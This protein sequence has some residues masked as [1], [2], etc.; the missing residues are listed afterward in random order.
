MS[1]NH[2]NDAKTSVKKSKKSWVKVAALSGFAAT[3]VVASSVVAACSGVQFKS[4]AQIVVSDS[5]STLADQSFSESAYDGLKGF[6]GDLGINTVPAASDSKV[7]ENNGLWKKPGQTDDDRVRTYVNVK[8]DGSNIVI[9]TG[10]NQSNALH[11]ITSQSK[12]QSNWNALKD[13]GFIFVDGSMTTDYKITDENGNVTDQ[14]TTD[15]T[16]VASISYRADDGSFLAGLATAV[17]LNENWKTFYPSNASAP[18]EIGASGYVGL[19]IPSTVSYLNGY[20]L[21]FMYWNKIC[22]LIELSDGN[23]GIPIKWITPTSDYAISTFA[24]NSFS[25]TEPRAETITTAL[26][27]NGAKAILPI[28]G[29]QTTLSVNTV[30]AQSDSVAV[31]GVDTA[32]EN[33]TSLQKP[34]PGGSGKT[35]NIIPFSTLKNITASVKGVLHA[36]KDGTNKGLTDAEPGYSGFGYN[37]VAD[38]TND[39]VGVSDAG[40]Q[41]LI[42]PLFFANQT[43]DS[44]SQGDTAPQ[45]VTGTTVSRGDVTNYT[46]YDVSTLLANAKQNSGTGGSTSNSNRFKLETIKRASASPDDL[47]SIMDNYKKLLTKQILINYEQQTGSNGQNGGQETTPQQAIATAIDWTITGN[48]LTKNDL[49]PTVTG[50]TQPAGDANLPVFTGDAAT[51]SLTEA[52]G[53]TVKTAKV[54]TGNPLVGT[55]WSY[56][57]SF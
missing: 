43:P 16:N 2:G 27:R 51:Y 6:Y 4:V 10:F 32:Q 49:T 28:A 21:G 26:I 7:V 36:I 57:F 15:P 22:S 53:A 23:A 11:R 55:G 48:E 34:M 18:T 20:R 37:N 33:I 5:T 47:K 44:S 46:Q 45:K 17:Y 19:A 8:N 12:D 56:A 50:T 42:D 3:A 9:A 38:L 41:Y 40:S 54:A 29:P 39:G 13:T 25:A 14:W 31:L 52:F 24:T 1:N 35:Q 30:A